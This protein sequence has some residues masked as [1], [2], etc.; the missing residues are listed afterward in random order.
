MKLIF[1][2]EIKFAADHKNI[3]TREMHNIGT[4]YIVVTLQQLIYLIYKDI[5][6]KVNIW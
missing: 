6:V 1:I 4:G 3:Y 2:R 5:Q